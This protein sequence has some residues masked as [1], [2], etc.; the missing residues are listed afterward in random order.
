MINRI[1][2]VKGRWKDFFP[3]FLLLILNSFFF[4]CVFGR[5]WS[6]LEDFFGKEKK[7]TTLLK[8]ISF[9]ALMVNDDP[10]LKALFFFWGRR[11]EKSPQIN[12][13]KEAK[14]L[15]IH[16]SSFGAGKH[17]KLSC[18]NYF[19]FWFVLWVWTLFFWRVGRIYQYLRIFKQKRFS[20][21]FRVTKNSQ[22]FVFGEKINRH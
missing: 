9:F 22:F 4:F 2:S 13:W 7:N 18:W 15:V 21:F 20:L 6:T 3:F 17:K 5:K 8:S 10:L 1:K 16:T 12:R 14:I 19:L 11:R